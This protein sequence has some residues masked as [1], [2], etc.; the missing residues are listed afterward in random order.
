MT[1]NFKSA[2][3]FR[4]LPSRDSVSALFYAAALIISSQIQCID[5]YTADALRDQIHNLTGA[6][7]LDLKFNQFS[8]YLSG[9]CTY[10]CAIYSEKI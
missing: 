9:L 3:K 5:A 7:N 4:G 6:E 10:Y 2:R 1:G 8:G